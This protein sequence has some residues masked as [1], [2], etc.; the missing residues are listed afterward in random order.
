[1]VPY[2]TGEL[3]VQQ[4]TGRCV[5]I[6]Y[7]SRDT[8]GTGGDGGGTRDATGYWGT[9]GFCMVLKGT[10]GYYRDRGWGAAGYSGVLEGTS[11]PPKVKSFRIFLLS[12]MFLLWHI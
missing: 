4:N 7:G 6:L 8:W 9:R 5:L 2:G 1:M 12:D 11:G 3:G 10:A